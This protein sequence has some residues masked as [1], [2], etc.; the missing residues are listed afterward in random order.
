MATSN[1]YLDFQSPREEKD[2]V[3][4]DLKHIK[5]P[6]TGWDVQ[7]MIQAEKG[8]KITHIEVTIGGFQKCNENPIPAVNKWNRSFTQQ[9]QYPGDNTVKVTATNDKTEDFSAEDTWS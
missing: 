5:N 6:A 3:T 4:F 8:E 2:H 9:G 7:V 1:R